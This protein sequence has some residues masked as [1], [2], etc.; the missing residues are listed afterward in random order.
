[1]HSDQ[2]TLTAQPGLLHDYPVEAATGDLFSSAAKS[3][4]EKWRVVAQGLG[5]LESGGATIDEQLS[6]QILDL[7]L[8]FRI[9]GDADERNWPLTPMPLIIGSDEWASIER[10]LIQRAELLERLAAD[11]YGPQQLVSGGRLPAAVVAGSPYFARR[12]LGQAPA[13]GNFINVYAA[14]L[15]R[16]PQ[17][18]WRVLADRVRLA[19][20]VGYALE[21]RLAM[22]RTT[23][24]LLA[25]AHARRLAD[26]FTCLREGIGRDC[27]REHPRVALLTPGRFNQTYPEQAHLARY[28]GLPLVEGRDLTV[29]DNRLYVRTIGGPRRIDAVW[30]WINTNALDPLTF[31]AKSS[32]GVANMVDAWASGSLAIV[33]RPGVEVLESPAFCA[34]M[35]RL[36]KILLGEDPL[37]P[38]VATWWCGQQAE[39]QTVANRLDE[40]ALVS[41]FGLPVDGLT[42]HLPVQGG[43]LD[44]GTKAALTEAMRRRPMD[45]CG[46]EIVHLS[47]TPALIEGE[48]VPR[49]FTLRAFVCRAGDGSWKVMPGGF[50]RLS[51]SD[52]LP[53]SLMGE[54]DLSAD[55]WVV[56]DQPHAATATGVMGLQPPV[57][58][59]GGLLSSQAAD[60]LY[61]FGRY[62]E[63]AEMTVRIVRGI[64]GSSIEV[65][66]GSTSDPEVRR[67]LAFLLA[68]W[69]A[70]SSET[71]NEPL[72][73]LCGKALGEVGLP[74]GVAA[75]IRRG[76]DVALVL[77]ERFARDFWRIVSKPMPPVD[78]Q[79][80]QA[81]LSVASGLIERF[82]AM[83]G[84]ANENMVRGNA[85]RF[86][87]LGKRIERALAT[88]RIAGHLSATSGEAQA[89][90]MLLDLC[91]SQ[92]I[93]RSRYLTGPLR[94]P[95]FDLVLLDPDN[96]R[97]LAY[98]VADITSHL[99][100]LPPLLDDNIPEEPY[101][102]ARAILSDLQTTTA[103]AVSG[104]WMSQIE[105]RLFEL[106]DAISTRYFLQFEKPDPA[107]QGALLA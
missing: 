46:Q 18:E 61:W 81:M 107:G 97:S 92:I 69:G 59:G 33:N 31:D 72:P 82:S 62:S 89:L 67:S 78:A 22:S 34:F 105:S 80:P 57:S 74:G 35:P 25:E 71:A 45:Y 15:A 100:A 16:G 103:E 10:G 47:T 73:V 98:Q 39:G 53:T 95:V 38:T 79:R 91:D 101:R 27:S 99:E 26:F 37:L 56:D 66:S 54:G 6:R 24:A 42:D 55:V 83:A 21:N 88:C 77:R 75:L 90:N 32:L 86:L 93:Y 48:L 5:S 28:L 76:Q 43:M 3:V 94:A 50:A 41:A 60:N 44:A 102:L 11:I 70:I 84:L 64:L 36:C 85:W 106:S 9:A 23:D 68:Q 52:E 12:M 19:T 29:T 51:S 58:R 63:R 8:T 104:D 13:S 1:M 65:D 17:G 49:P 2:T 7:G 30:R 40:L 87:N 96:P 20:G 14:D 4:A